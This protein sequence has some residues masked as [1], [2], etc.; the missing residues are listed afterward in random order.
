MYIGNR[1]YL[2]SQ[3]CEPPKNKPCMSSKPPCKQAP[4]NQ[5]PYCVFEVKCTPFD[6]NPPQIHFELKI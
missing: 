4:L 5:T 1:R 2:C 3:P 6:D